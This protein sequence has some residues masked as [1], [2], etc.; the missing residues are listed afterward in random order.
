MDKLDNG[1]LENTLVILSKL[2]DAVKNEVAKWD[3]YYKLVKK[4]HA[5]Q[6]ID[7]TNLVE[8]ADHNTKVGGIEK[9][10]LHHYYD[11]YITTRESNKLKADNFAVRLAQENSATKADID[12]LM[13]EQDLDDKLK[14]LNKKLLQIKQI[15]RGWKE[16]HWSKRKSNKYQKNDFLLGRIM[17]F[18]GD[19][20]YQNSHFFVPF[21]SSLVLDSN[22]NVTNSISTGISTEKT[23]LF[24]TN[25]EMTTSNLAKGRIIWK[26]N[27]LNLYVI[28]DLNNCPSNPTNNFPLNVAY[29]VQSN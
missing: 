10:I 12:D 26:F 17:Y 6:T 20:G 5:I 11:K 19:D 8:K 2:G 27:I 24:D 7:T 9:K 16:T 14:N 15:C 29:L 3:V 18:T 23:K 1:K 28:C 22:K 4:V 21:V 13:E 25:L